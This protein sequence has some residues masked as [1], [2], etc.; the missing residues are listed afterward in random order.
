[1][2]SGVPPQWCGAA[3]QVATASPPSQKL[4]MRRPLSLS[5]PQP[6]QC[7]TAPWSWNASSAMG[8]L[9]CLV[10]LQRCR[11][12]TVAQVRR[13][14]AVFE[15][16][17]EVRPALVAQGFRAPHQKTIVVLG[18]HVVLRR[19]RPETRPTGAGVELGVRAE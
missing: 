13:L 12:D 5:A 15:D 19:R 8:E 2:F 10:E 7:R 16:V 1:R 17:A 11:I 4:L 9:F 18:G 14:R 3:R 6:W